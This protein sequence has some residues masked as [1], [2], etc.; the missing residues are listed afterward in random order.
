VAIVAALVIVAVVYVG[1]RSGS[2]PSAVAKH[3]AKHI[4]TLDAPPGWI[5]LPLLL[6]TGKAVVTGAMVAN[7]PV[8]VPNAGTYEDAYEGSQTTDPPQ[9]LITTVHA[10]PGAI[11]GYA[12]NSQ[13]IAVNGTVAYLTSFGDHQLV[14]ETSDGVVVSLESFGMTSSDVVAAAQL[15]APNPVAQ[16]GVDVSGPL[17]DGLVLVGAGFAGG[18]TSQN[19]GDSVFFTQGSCHAYTQ[20]W[21]GGPADFAPVAIV[22]DASRLVTVGGTPALLAQIDPATRTLLWSPQP[23]VDVRLQG[24]DC[25]LTG[26]ASGLKVV[27]PATWQAQ[28][29]ALG[30]KAQVFTPQAPISPATLPGPGTFGLAH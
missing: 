24:N 7:G 4:G 21:A 26:I 6:P 3:P 27:D 17:P 20:V 13:T 9:L 28:M 29:S 12:A 5:N 8:S 22:S 18:E 11:S 10:Q 25:D 2:P 1:P 15:V 23:G 19:Q 14:W 30:S 16:L